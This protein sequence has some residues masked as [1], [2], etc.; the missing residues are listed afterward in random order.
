MCFGLRG[1][2]TVK[3]GQLAHL[4]RNPGHP[5]PENL[6]F[7]CQGCHAIYDKRSNRVLGFTP[8]EVRNYRGQLYA[9]LGHD[10][11]EWSLTI[12][13]DHAEFA[14][15]KVVVDQAHALLLA[16]SREVTRREGPV[17]L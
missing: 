12:R 6:A 10:A 7:L 11:F 13:A 8:A 15:A 1:D 4:D 14:A 16:F 9:A 5:A 17:R 3:E 2:L